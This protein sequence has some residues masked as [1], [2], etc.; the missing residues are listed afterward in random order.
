MLSELIEATTH[1]PYFFKLEKYLKRREV[2]TKYAKVCIGELEA[3]LE[4]VELENATLILTFADQESEQAFNENKDEHYL[5]RFRSLYL[6]AKLMIEK[7]G[8]ESNL[9]N[10]SLS[11][12]I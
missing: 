11:V 10:A 4:S 7:L 3:K 1:A 5:P 2:I 12:R 6:E 8:V 9:L